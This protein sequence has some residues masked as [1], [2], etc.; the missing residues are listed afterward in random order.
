MYLIEPYGD[1]G[2]FNN[3]YEEIHNF[4]QI[5]AD[6]GY[7][8]HFHWG[9]F[10]WMM[11]G[12]NLDVGMLSK[13]ALF[14]DESGKLVGVVMF[15]TVYHD[16]WYI[17]HSTS[18]EILLRQMIEYVARTEEVGPITIKANQN[19]TV[20]CELLDHAGY[21]KQ[22]S[23]SV[24]EIDLPCNS[25]YRLPEGFHLN[26]PTS[27]I[28]RWQWELVIYRGFDHEGVPEEKSGEEREAEKH[29]EITEYIKVFAIK[30]GEYTAHCGVWY[31]G[32]ETAYIEP[33]VTVPEHRGKGLGKAVV[34]EAI[35]R[36]RQRGAKRAIVLSDQEFYKRLGMKKSS[37]VGT[38]VKNSMTKNNAGP[39]TR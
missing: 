25:S 29:L 24:L 10:D 16:R 15:D 12:S 23:E 22:Y 21:E 7:N 13:N 30:D 39:I 32:G 19:D 31:D 2:R 6:S 14:K 1:T 8:E 35:H 18:D 33:V 3:Q 36:A 20:L 17:L 34:Y 38:W 26:A 28:D 5:I 4:L 27:Q 37:E 11:S 9:R